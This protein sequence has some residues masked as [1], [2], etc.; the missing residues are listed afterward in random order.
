MGKYKL[1]IRL[2]IEVRKLT[3]K[4]AI[5]EPSLDVRHGQGGAIRHVA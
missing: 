5:Y 1:P 4:Q 2:K 3:G